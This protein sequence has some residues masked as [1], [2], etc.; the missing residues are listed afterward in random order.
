[1]ISFIIPAFNEEDII[2]DTISRLREGAKDVRH[3]I[4]LSDDGSTDRTREIGAEAGARVVEYSGEIPK[5]IGAARNRGARAALFPLLVF[6]DSDVRIRDSH[7][8]FR[9]AL[10]HFQA[11]EQLAGL[12]VSIRVYS[13]SETR[14]DRIVFIL[15]DMYFRTANF[16]GFG[17]AQKC[18][19]VRKTAFLRA[20]GFNESLAAAEDL[21]LFLRLSKF[22]R[23]AFDA[24][25]RAYFSGRR[26]HEIGWP[27]LLWRWW[28]DSLWLF[29][30]KRSYSRSW[31]RV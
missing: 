15:S 28:R 11:E 4:I 9:K 21:D 25:M 10:V 8:F 16:L 26:A 30:F 18:M 17:L 24:S 3:E 6:L 31:R 19:L 20:G 12:A 22:A 13:E 29:L 5:T 27:A 14:T 1:M 7:A 23:T 2:A